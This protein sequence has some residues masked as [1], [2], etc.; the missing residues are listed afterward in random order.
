MSDF[1]LFATAPRGCTS[2]LLE[3]LREM[4]VDSPREGLA[5]VAFRGD[6]RMA[7]R[8]CLW[9]R[10]ASRVLLELDRFHAYDED[11]LYAGIQRTDWDD[12]LS[13][14]GTLAVNFTS[15]LSRISHT[16]YGALKVK[17]AIVDQFRER[18][19]RRPSVD[20]V[21]PDLRLHVHIHRND[22][23][24]SIDLSGDSLHRRGYRQGQVKAPMKENLAAA[25]LLRA[26]WPAV[27]RQGG[28]FLDPMCGSGTLPIEAA[29]IAGDIA[30]GLLRDR[31]GFEG[32][33][34]HRPRVWSDLLAEAGER[35][36]A[37]LE[38]MPPIY[39][40]DRDREAIRIANDSIA[41]AGLVWKAHCERRALGSQPLPGS[42]LRESGMLVTNPP[43]GERLGDKERLK[44]T[45]ARLGELMRDELPAGWQAAVFT[46][47][48]EL[49]YAMRVRAHRSHKFFNGAL[50]CKLLRFKDFGRA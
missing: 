7:Y 18:S 32:W 26:G 3:E 39:G 15:S 48:P 23:T 28:G 1:Q 36:R 2:V 11:A 9:S 29:M 5:G 47:N 27:A 8:V 40:F 12:H 10:S 44:E 4:G 22:A 46:G 25:V 20:T 42:L 17:D 43:Y 45:Y 13:V 35:R 49:G 38:H 50:E 41:A 14:D 21:N 16:H 30:P 19:G 24:V 33:R 34:Q 37:G 6:L 31:F